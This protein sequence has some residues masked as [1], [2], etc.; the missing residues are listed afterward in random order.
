MSEEDNWR[1]DRGHWRAEMV[2]TSYQ[3]VKSELVNIWSWVLENF[4]GPI[5]IQ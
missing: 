3:S 5:T 4:E 1:E 2:N